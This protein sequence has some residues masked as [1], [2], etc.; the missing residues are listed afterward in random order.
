[1]GE[2]FFQV[3]ET[4]VDSI[5]SKSLEISSGIDGEFIDANWGNFSAEELSE[6]FSVPINIIELRALFRGHILYYKDHDRCPLCRKFISVGQS[7]CIDCKEVGQ[8]EKVKKEKGYSK[9]KAYKHYY[10]ICS[11]INKGKHDIEAYRLCPI[12]RFPAIMTLGMEKHCKV[13]GEDFYS[14][15]LPKLKKLYDYLDKFDGVMRNDKTHEHR[16]GKDISTSKVKESVCKYLKEDKPVDNNLTRELF[17]DKSEKT[18]FYQN[19]IGAKRKIA[20]GVDV[21]ICPICLMPI[22][23]KGFCCHAKFHGNEFVDFIAD[24]DLTMVFD[25]YVGEDIGLQ[26]YRERLVKLP[27]K[28]EI[29]ESLYRKC[30][31][32]PTIRECLEVGTKVCTVDGIK[33]VGDLCVGDVVTTFSENGYIEDKAIISEFNSVENVVNENFKVSIKSS[34]ND[35]SVENMVNENFK[36]S[37]KS[38]VNDEFV[39]KIKNRK[40]IKSYN[41]VM[42]IASLYDGVFD[43]FQSEDSFINSIPSRMSLLNY[44]GDSCSSSIIIYQNKVI[45]LNKELDRICREEELL[46]GIAGINGIE[47]IKTRYMC[48]KEFTKLLSEFRGEGHY[49]M[50]E[51]SCNGER[52]N[53]IKILKIK[54]DVLFFKDG[55]KFYEDRLILV[56]NLDIPKFI[57]KIVKEEDEK[58]TIAIKS[59]IDGNE[60]DLPKALE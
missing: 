46:K 20:K 34:V 22:S 14:F 1:M 40:N 11:D 57:C 51:R 10:R 26:E 59:L 44:K 54:A 2:H 28:E 43:D 36:V 47:V 15:I 45:Q 52:I 48:Q 32:N 24:H 13:H 19:F 27:P 5:K 38:A 50:A 23:K 12:C 7:K 58:T 49:E 56:G 3:N 30:G 25:K 29:I 42:G 18:K 39:V 31:V 33:N 9:D 6:L 53:V 60:L 17:Q 8:V 41:E 4:K 35:Q 55:D 16:Y 21:F 37:I